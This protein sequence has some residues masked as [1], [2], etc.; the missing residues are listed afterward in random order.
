MSFPLRPSRSSFGPKRVN[1]RPSRNPNQELDDNAINAFLWTV[2]GAGLMVAMARLQ[3]SV[4]AGVLSLVAH[5]EAFQPDG[6]APP[7]TARTSQGVYTFAFSAS[8]PDEQ[9][10]QQPL[11]LSYGEVLCQGAAFRHG[12]VQLTDAVS[13]TIRIFDQ[14]AAAQDCAAFAVHL[15]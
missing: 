9:G 2:A 5:V 7:A 14:A 8:Y 6:G 15:W 10:N 3:F 1:A 12:L 4:A 11:S 13:G